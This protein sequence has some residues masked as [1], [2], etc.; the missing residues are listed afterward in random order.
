MEE[1]VFRPARA[2]KTETLV[3]KFLDRAFGHFDIPRFAA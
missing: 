2:D 3:R 1:Q